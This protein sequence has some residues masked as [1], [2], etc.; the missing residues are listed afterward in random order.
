MLTT[1][2]LIERITPT[3]LAEVIASIGQ[4]NLT[5]RE[6]ETV[7]MLWGALVANV[8]EEEASELLAAAR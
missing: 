5:D 4:V 8:G 3:A 6:A 7:D 2:E 1:L